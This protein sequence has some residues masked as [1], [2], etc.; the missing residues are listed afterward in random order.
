MI[1]GMLVKELGIKKGQVESAIKLIDEGNTIPFIARY[2]KEMTG[3]LSDETLRQLHERLTYLR[4]LESRKQ[5]VIRIIDE[6]GKLT[7]ELEKAISSADILQKVEDL[8][9]PYKQKKSTR[10]EKAR[11]RGLEP[12]SKAIIEGRSGI[13]EFAASFVDAEKEVDTAEAAIAGAKDIIAEGVSDNAAYRQWIRELCTRT[14]VL[15][16]QATDKDSDSVYSNYYEFSEPISKAADHRILAINRGESEKFLRVRLVF[17]DDRIVEYLKSKEI[18]SAN[19]C[20]SYIEEAIEDAYKRLIQPSIERELRSGLTERAQ[21]NAIALFG[22]N[23]K[24]LIMAPPVK[25]VSVLAIDP[26]FRTGCKLSVLDETGKLLEYSTIYPNAPKND[27]EKSKQEMLRLIEK[28]K[29]DIISIGNGTASRETE[30]FVAESIKDLKRSVHYTIVSEAGASVY[31]ASKLANEEYPDIDVSIRG[32][33]SIGRRLQDPMAELVKIDPKSIG[34]GQY[35]HD[36]N[37][38]RLDEALKGVVEDCVNSVGV[39]LN[40]ATV[41]LLKYVSGISESIAKNIVAYRDDNGRFNCRQELKKVK[42]L[43]DK[44]FEQCAGFLRIHGGVNPLDNTAVHPE[45]YEAAMRLLEILGIDISGSTKVSIDKSKIDIKALCEQTCIG[46][47]TLGDI[48]DELLKPGRDPR[49]ELPKPILRSDVLSIEDLKVGMVLSGTVRNV[50]DFGAFV[51][52]GV[53]NDGLVHISQICERFI[54]HPM[55]VLSVGDIINVRIIDVNHE[56]GKVS[57]SMKDI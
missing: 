7:K 35:Q 49:D 17:P 13:L 6:Q 51:D 22:K 11:E 18:K 10:A 36:L 43:G 20:T 33:I 31:S 45:S 48:V 3:G 50:V 16:S 21:E 44:A 57:L 27:T 25:D 56:K 23:L 53:K 14:A 4:N 5:E 46:E 38:K 9:R 30:A 12:L 34:V 26:S 28:H 54:K 2:R 1:T 40:T 8:Y 41:S 24:G 32:A 47:L 42:R 15:S 37:Q 55:E 52:I 39:D 19:E 29:I